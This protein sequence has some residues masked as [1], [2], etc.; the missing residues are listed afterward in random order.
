MQRRDEV[1]RSEGRI[2]KGS[3]R[4]KDPPRGTIGG[5]KGDDLLRG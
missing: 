1:G 4:M 3:E 2:Q 5:M